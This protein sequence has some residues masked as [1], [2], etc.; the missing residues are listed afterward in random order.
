[1]L[2]VVGFENE[3][4]GYCSGGECEYITINEKRTVVHSL[5]KDESVEFLSQA[6]L[7]KEDTEKVIPLSLARKWFN[8]PI[9]ALLKEGNRFNESG[10]FYCQNSEYGDQHDIGPH[11]CMLQIEKVTITT[12]K[13]HKS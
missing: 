4:S 5:D 1:M 2:D 13:Q 7:T 3:H 9:E 12:I 10:S 11:E 6:G 8:E